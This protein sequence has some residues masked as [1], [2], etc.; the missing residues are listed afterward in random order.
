[1]IY[2]TT[3][4]KADGNELHLNTLE[5]IW[6]KGKLKMWGR[7]SRIARTGGSQ[8]VFSRLLAT[9]QITKAAL[10]AAISQ[11]RKSGLSKDELFEIFGDLNNPKAHSNLFY[12]TDDEG[13]LMDS[14]VGLVLQSTPGLIGIL[15][16][17]YIHKKKRYTMAEEMQEAHP[18]LSISTC[19]RRI[20]VWVNTAEY[21]LYR[22]MSDAFD[23]DIKR[24]EKKL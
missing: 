15:Q 13:L 12:C 9:Q 1:M 17:H 2:P 6:L 11:L 20:D 4:G 8:G 24:F 22:P 10:K 18:E 3:C 19:R 23:K 7:W 14:V 16:Q 5:L 21:M